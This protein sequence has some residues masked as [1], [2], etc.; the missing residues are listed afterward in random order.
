MQTELTKFYRPITESQKATTKGITESQKATARE[1]TEGLRPIREGIEKL[2]QAMQPIGEKTG[3]EEEEEEDKSVGD[4]ARKWLNRLN[5]DKTF[6]INKIG[7]HHYIGDTHVIVKENNNIFIDEEEF[8]GTPGLWKLI[9]SKYPMDGDFTSKDYENYGRIL[10]KTHVLHQGNN[11]NSPYPKSSKSDK[12]LGILSEIWRHRKEFGGKGIVIMPSDPNA[13]L[14]RLDLLLASQKAGH[15]GVGN[16]LVSI[17][18]E[19]K[20]Q[21]VLDTEAYKKL[22]SII[23]NDST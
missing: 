4:I 2:P 10:I 7:K 20:R 1:I 11:P 16:E 21:G 17:C 12:W 9:M 19:L 8:E 15:T 23:K 22:N 18:D 13:L 3:E 14:E 6:G 5:T